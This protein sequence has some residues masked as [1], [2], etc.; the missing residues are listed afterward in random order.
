MESKM[1]GFTIQAVVARIQAM[2]GDFQW[3]R[4]SALCMLGCVRG[5]KTSVLADKIF[6]TAKPSA[7][8]RKAVTVANAC[9]GKW[10]Q[11][12]KAEIA[13]LTIEEAEAF[14]LARLNAHMTALGVDGRDAYLAD[15][16]YDD[17]AEAEAAKAIG[18][19][20]AKAE[21]EA[22]AEAAKAEAEAAA[23]AQAEAEAK[24]KAEAESRPA[25][26]IVAEMVTQF[27]TMSDAELAS[28]A[29]AL[30]AEHNRRADLL[31]LANDGP[32][33]AT[34]EEMAGLIERTTKGR[35]KAA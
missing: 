1:A 7:S 22:K 15:A 3:K 32:R 28:L 12:H 17:K 16:K 24:A 13:T 35:K 21:A 6:G 2:D 26:D 34:P 23:Q 14:A 27:A 11:S 10:T 8:F 20:D 18:E 33:L 19:A 29:S 31:K 5:T 25:R 9:Y 30:H 4:Y